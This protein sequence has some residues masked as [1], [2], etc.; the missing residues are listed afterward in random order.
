MIYMSINTH[1]YENDVRVMIQAFYPKEKIITDPSRAAE[2]TLRAE[3]CVD[4]SRI[5]ACIGRENGTDKIECD[6][7]TFERKAVRNRLKRELYSVFAGLTGTELPW[8]TLT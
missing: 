1:G 3:I 6:T 5:R 7:G 8:G 4:G 2:C